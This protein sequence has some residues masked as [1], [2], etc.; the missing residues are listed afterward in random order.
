MHPDDTYDLTHL[1]SWLF[2]TWEPLGALPVPDTR[3]RAG[4]PEEPLVMGVRWVRSLV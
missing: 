3:I 2:V 4:H 1:Y